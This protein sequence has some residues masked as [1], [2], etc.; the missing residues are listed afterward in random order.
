MAIVGSTSGVSL[1]LL[2]GASHKAMDGFRWKAGVILHETMYSTPQ[3]NAAA[4]VFWGKANM[5][6]TER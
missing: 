3:A 5:G 4:R 2:F 1:N 6:S